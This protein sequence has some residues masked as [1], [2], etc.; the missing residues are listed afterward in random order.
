MEVSVVGSGIDV[1]QEV[2][3][4]AFRLLA[5][6]LKRFQPGLAGGGQVQTNHFG[7]V[8]GPLSRPNLRVRSPAGKV[9]AKNVG[10]FGGQR[11]LGLFAILGVGGLQADQRRFGSKVET[12]RRQGCQ[13][14][15]TQPR[16]SG[17]QIQCE[18]IRPGQ[19]TIG[20]VAGA[21]CRE[22]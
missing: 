15:Y 13:L 21:D 4:L 19:V 10:N 6:I 22:K 11:Q 3:L 14:T 12:A 17:S 18:S 1:S 20:A 8:L 2:A 7:R 16:P 5:G 9:V